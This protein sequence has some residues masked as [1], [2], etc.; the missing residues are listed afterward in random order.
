M[1]IKII[2]FG[3]M[4]PTIYSP[5]A[6][7]Y[8]KRLRI[9]DHCEVLELKEFVNSNLQ[10]TIKQNTDL[11]MLKLNKFSTSE[12]IILTVDGTLMTSEDFG[13]LL[14]VNKWN[15][16]RDLIFVVGPSDGLE[17][18]RFSRWRHISLGRITLPHQLCRIVLLEQIYR[19]FKILQNETYHK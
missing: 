5:I 3:R 19:G 11:L 8:L 14:V 4:A 1:P 15:G 12:I 16:R 9:Y 13:Q 6:Q 17:M 10:T 2:A 7:E 18:K